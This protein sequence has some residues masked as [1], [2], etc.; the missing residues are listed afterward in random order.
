MEFGEEI[1]EESFVLVSSRSISSSRHLCFS[2]SELPFE[3]PA[4]HPRFS[5]SQYFLGSERERMQLT[6][7][8]QPPSSAK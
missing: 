5:L 2:S 8:E 1:S 7:A 4:Y 3:H 6:E